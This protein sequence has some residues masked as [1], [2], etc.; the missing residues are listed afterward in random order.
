MH[1]F[2]TYFFLEYVRRLNYDELE[3]SLYKSQKYVITGY[4]LTLAVYTLRLNFKRYLH[5][6]LM[7]NP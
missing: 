2:S 7:Y 4:G 6:I 3:S 5:C 1:H